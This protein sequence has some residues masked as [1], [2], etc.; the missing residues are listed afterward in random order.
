MT[1][2]PQMFKM[3]YLAPAPPLSG[4][5]KQRNNGG[6]STEVEQ[7][8]SLSQNGTSGQTAPRYL[9]VCQATQCIVHKGVNVVYDA[10]S[11]S[12]L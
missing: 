11:I 3:T 4:W 7:G 8:P 5:L 1:K 10:L 6:T 9:V 12:V 2:Q